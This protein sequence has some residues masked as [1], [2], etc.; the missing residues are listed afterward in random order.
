MK[1]T[2]QD[3]LLQLEQLEEYQDLDLA[4]NQRKIEVH[5]RILEIL[6]EEGL[7]W[8]KRS[9]SKW[10]HEGDNNTEF[11]HRMANGK[12]R[13][14]TIISFMDGNDVIE[15]ESNLCN[16]ATEF[17]KNLYGP[18]PGNTF[19]LNEDLWDHGEKITTEDNEMLTQ[20]FS[21]TEIRTRLFGQT[22]SQ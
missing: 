21:K 20:P 4:Q 19:P 7:Y 18:V 17:Y 16:H 11:F 14:N 10:L 1:A 12:K 3:E 6:D 9:H 8:Y 15:G 13:K 5:K 2:L 22:K